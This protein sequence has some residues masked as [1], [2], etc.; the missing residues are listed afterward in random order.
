[1]KERRGP[2]PVGRW[3]E[4]AA[5]YLASR[6]VSETEANAEFLMAHVLGGGWADARA[7]TYDVQVELPDLDE[8]GAY[9]RTIILRAH[10]R[11]L[12]ESRHDAYTSAVLDEYIE[13]H[14]PPFTVDYVRLNL[15]ATKPTSS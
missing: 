14:G 10:I 9:L 8:A 2:I 13:R 1:M 3:L 11:H 5:F 12:P 15:W 7:D 6:G 4:K